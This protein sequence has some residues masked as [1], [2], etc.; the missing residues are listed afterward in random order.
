MHASGDNDEEAQQKL[1]DNQAEVE[2]AI[3]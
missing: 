3:K 1:L 2:Q